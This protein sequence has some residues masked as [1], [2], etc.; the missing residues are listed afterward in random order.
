MGLTMPAM[1]IWG[2]DL[3]ISYAILVSLIGGV[4][5]ILLMI[6][7]RRQ[8]IV[9]MH[10][11]LK[12]PEGIASAKV[13]ETLVDKGGRTI[14][15]GFGFS[16]V[17]S[18]LMDILK[19]WKNY[20]DKFFGAPMRTASVSIEL[21][22]LLVGIG[23]I[24]GSRA[25]STMCAGGFFA[26]L[27]LNPLISYLGSGVQS[28][29][30]P[31]N[32]PIQEMSPLELR[33]AYLIYIG[34]GA[35]AASGIFSVLRSLPAIWH[36]L[37]AGYADL[38]DR[39]AE[40]YRRDRTNQDLPMKVVVGGVLLLLAPTLMMKS[41]G[42]QLN[43]LGVALIVILGFIYVSVSARITGE[44]GTSATPTS[45][46][47]VGVLLL[48]CLVFLKVGWTGQ[49]Y[50]L[51]ALTIGAIVGVAV[52][53]GGITSQVLKTGFL[54]GA[55]PRHQ[56]TA[57]L[58]GAI[59]SALTLG[60]LLV[61]L[62][63][64][65]T[66]YVPAIT[67]VPVSSETANLRS[68]VEMSSLPAFT[69]KLAPPT[70]GNYRV[71][72]NR[73]DQNPVPGLD[74]GEYLVN[75]SGRLAYKV[76][77]IFATDLRPDTT[78]L[79]SP[80]RLIGVQANSDGSSY[81]LWRKLSREGGP[82][83][84]YLIND[85]GLAVYFV[86]PGINGFVDTRPDGS[87]VE[88]F[89]APRAALF[90]YVI[91]G[92]LDQQLPWLLVLLGVMIAV[93]MELCQVSSLVFAVGLY[94]PLSTSMPILLGGMI[95]MVIERQRRRRA[96]KDK[97]VAENEEQSPGVLMSSGYIAGGVIAAILT[98]LV[99]DS[100]FD[101]RMLQWARGSNPFYSGP[102]ADSLSLIPFGIMILILYMIG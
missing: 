58:L 34:A 15:F 3:E 13:A 21:S 4:L 96:K 30:S 41:L 40:K 87:H 31:A 74:F 18:F 42:L 16:F 101:R 11:Q 12:Y 98:A 66:V 61:R 90:S 94:L 14:F 17:Y 59:I 71:L 26:Y 93:V 50:Y 46:F 78:Q 32:V 33:S 81:R 24:V 51:T 100:A 35:I 2:L 22:P 65:S 25:A 57:I 27:V 88:K 47:I 68:N 99:V 85:D 76:E 45:G 86:D 89:A 52:S 7:L 23:Y 64:S 63:E 55:T 39:N 60:P 84:Q 70:A 83:G 29:V 28:P 38:R 92:I 75:E 36:S 37:K 95:R 56:Q 91:R 82:P 67:F 69:E 10:G 8:F 48:T 102:N 97:P 77:R 9:Q 19:S 5:G 80:S 54:L 49:A 62:N 1:L 72:N 53:M 44:L 20:A 73:S 6:P 79:G 43:F